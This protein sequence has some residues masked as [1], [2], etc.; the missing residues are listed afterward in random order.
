MLYQLSYSRVRGM[1][2]RPFAGVLAAV[3]PWPRR[4]APPTAPRSARRRRASSSCVPASAT[5]PGLEDVDAVGV[6]DRREPVRDDDRRAP[7]LTRAQRALDRRLGLVVDRAGRLV[8][9][10]DRGVA[11]DRPRD[12]QPLA[13]AAARA[14]RRARRPA[15]RSPAGSASTNSCAS[16]RSRRLAQRLVGC[17][18]ARRSAGSRATVPSKRNVSC[19]D[20]ADRAAQ[21][22]RRRSSRQ[23]DAVDASAR[24]RRRRRGAAAA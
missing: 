5:T 24:R 10:E 17:V 23:R 3:R 12:R 19:A 15:C 22:T 1:L 18:R 9:H 13:L 16:A 7:S 6:A 14:G 8:E 2:Q 21:A 11:H 4:S 20:V